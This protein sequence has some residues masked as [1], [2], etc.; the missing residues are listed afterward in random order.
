MGADLFFDVYVFTPDEKIVHSINLSDNRNVCQL[1]H[2][3]KIYEINA[4]DLSE[5][6]TEEEW[7]IIKLVH[8]DEVEVAF[9]KIEEADKLLPIFRKIS[10]LLYST[11][12]LTDTLKS[13]KIDTISDSRNTNILR[14]HFS[15]VEEIGEI[16]GVLLFAKAG[17][18]KVQFASGA[19]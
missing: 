4:I 16:N 10:K 5:S 1:L 3:G 19:W 12:H 11:K 2:E 9:S 17:N 15:F 7:S 6:L 8:S 14:T 13:L 18:H